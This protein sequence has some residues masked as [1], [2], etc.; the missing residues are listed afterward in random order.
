MSVL[1]AVV[2]RG[3]AGPVLTAETG[4]LARTGDSVLDVTDEAFREGASQ[5]SGFGWLLKARL[6]VETCSLGRGG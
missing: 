6:F 5:L 1:C 4:C 3:D 2:F